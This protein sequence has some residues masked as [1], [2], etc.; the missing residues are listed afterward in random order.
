MG[1]LKTL[2]IFFISFGLM[3]L[4]RENIKRTILRQRE[5]KRIADYN[6]I[7]PETEN[8]ISEIENDNYEYIP[9]KIYTRGSGINENGYNFNYEGNL[10]N[11]SIYKW[12]KDNNV[13]EQEKLLNKHKSKDAKYIKMSGYDKTEYGIPQTYLRNGD[14]LKNITNNL[15]D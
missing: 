13:Q 3:A 4:Y 6:N 1:H 12:N 14:F 2:L 8:F 11:K 9:K 15:L 10:R 7:N 5:K